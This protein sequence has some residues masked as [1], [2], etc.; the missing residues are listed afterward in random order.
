MNNVWNDGEPKRGS[1][2]FLCFPKF[3]NEPFDSSRI[4]IYPVHYSGFIKSEYFTS[5]SNPFLIISS[6]REF[7]GVHFLG[8]KDDVEKRTN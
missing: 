7:E 4:I 2:V 1:K 6:T 5:I 8:L 3:K